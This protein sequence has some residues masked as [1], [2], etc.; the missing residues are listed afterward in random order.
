MRRLL[1]FRT[2]KEDSICI[3]RAP[4][5]EKMKAGSQSGAEAEAGIQMEDTYHYHAL[6]L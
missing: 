2:E 6:V 1:V 5:N 4:E 3:D